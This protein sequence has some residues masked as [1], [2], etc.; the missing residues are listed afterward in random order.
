MGSDRSWNVSTVVDTW[1]GGKVEGQPGFP[2][3]RVLPCPDEPGSG[4]KPQLP[5]DRCAAESQLPSPGTRGALGPGPASRE[6]QGSGG[7]GRRASAP[8]P[9]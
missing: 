4:P 7:T 2:S 5:D 1:D 9:S 3:A 6:M 8:A